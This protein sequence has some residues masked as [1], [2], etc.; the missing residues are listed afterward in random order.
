MDSTLTIVMLVT[1][2]VFVINVYNS[3]LLQLGKKRKRYWSLARR[4]KA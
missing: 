4:R 1:L 2:R 3:V